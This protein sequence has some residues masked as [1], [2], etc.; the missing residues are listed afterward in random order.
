M[1]DKSLLYNQV[2]SK[3]KNFALHSIVNECFIKG[4]FSDKTLK[5]ME[6]NNR[7]DIAD[8]SR[9]S[10]AVLE[11][12]GGYSVLENAIKNCED[13]KQR[14]MLEDIDYICTEASKKATQRVVDDTDVDNLKDSREVVSAATFTKQEMNDFIKN[15]EK[16]DTD[17]ISEIIREKTK[18]V[19]KEEKESFKRDEEIENEIT[20]MINSQ[21]EDTDSSNLDSDDSSSQDTSGEDVAKESYGK[22]KKKCKDD[23]E[24]CDDDDDEDDDDEIDDDEDDDEDDDDFDDGM[25]G[26]KSKG[27]TKCKS[28]GKS[29]KKC[30]AATESYHKYLDMVLSDN[31][32]RHH[33]SLFS[34]LQEAA[35]E[36]TLRYGNEEENL[37]EIINR[38]TFESF[39]PS[40]KRDLTADTCIE[41]LIQMQND[42]RL[43]PNEEPDM[44]HVMKTATMCSTII[45]TAMETLNTLNLFTPSRMEIKDFVD[46]NQSSYKKDKKCMES[47]DSLV[48]EKLKDYENEIAK[49]SSIS[50]L[51]DVYAKL[52][53]FKDKIEK[54]TITG[55]E[56]FSDARESTINIMNNLIKT[57]KDKIDGKYTKALESVVKPDTSYYSDYKKRTDISQFIKINNLIAKR[58]DVERI[59][60]RIN[61]ANESSVS[62]YGL[63]KD[64][65]KV[66]E[67][68]MNLVSISDSS[69]LESSL[70]EL[71]NNSV[72]YQSEKETSIYYADGTGKE[73]HLK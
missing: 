14:L 48:Q 54:I 9:Y 51:T 40:L 71:Y 58:P 19:I 1:V 12:L 52:S 21:D 67:S 49:E 47:F 20:E 28:K 30:K 27:K 8:L 65:R 68:F 29:K 35:I 60:L 62:V 18:S 16:I 22:C 66:C 17:K 42:N 39:L 45:Y 59:Q 26:C 31:M 46:R 10:Y 3:F 11:S 73:I 64:G 44:R 23:D 63:S 50:V 25:E 55:N 72:L 7:D 43:K 38:T 41:S 61:P 53:D 37:M 6:E 33:V 34:K 4:I 2:L 69:A 36:S 57:T 56:L 70:R 13:S 5:E 15:G 24:E 32:P